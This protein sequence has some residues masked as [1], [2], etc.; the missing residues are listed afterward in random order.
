MNLNF[1]KFLKFTEQKIMALE[2]LP[3]FT[4][5]DSIEEIRSRNYP[6]DR[7]PE[8]YFKQLPDL[9]DYLKP[10]SEVLDIG[11][12]IG[13]AL[14]EIRDKYGCRV[15]GTG[16]RKIPDAL[17]PLVIADARNLPFPSNSFDLTIA[18][19][20]ISWCPDQIRAINEV[21]RVTRPGGRILINLLKFSASV[22]IWFGES[23]WEEAGVGYDQYGQME[24]HKDIKLENCRFTITEIYV[25]R[26]RYKYKYYLN[27]EKAAQKQI[28]A[29]ALTITHKSIP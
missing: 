16:I 27:L 19:H 6:V 23:F 11:P 28:P 17:V 18:V 5:T 20:S 15:T 7:N 29:F 22:D 25:P 13:K 2:K 4:G 8:S 12:G 26:K 9:P 3:P 21:V 24:F 10:E 14:S 1:K